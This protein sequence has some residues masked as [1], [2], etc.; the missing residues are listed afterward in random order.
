MM[1]E[2]ITEQKKLQAELD[3]VKLLSIKSN[4]TERLRLAQ[5]LHDEPLQYL[6]GLIFLLSDLKDMFPGPESQQIL[7]NYNQTLNRAINS[8]RAICGE[9]RP[10]SLTHF[11]LDG[12]I[13]DHAERFQAQYPSI[14]VKL[15]LMFDYQILSE[16]VRLSLFRIYQ[17]SM[18]NVVRH[19][20]ASQITVRF[21]WD[22]DQIVLEVQ[23]NGKGFVVPRHWID[24]VR[25][26]HMGLLGAAERIEM[27]HGK[28]EIISEPGKGTLIRAVTPRDVEIQTES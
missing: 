8:L 6:Y 4:E 20:E 2:D 22:Y 25:Q 23:D 1:V 27:L 9:L 17:Q 7:T 14:K 11:G 21:Y 15:D 18:I 26:G 13:R 19:A 12:A 10:P 3:E 16:T 24:S 5:D 28:L